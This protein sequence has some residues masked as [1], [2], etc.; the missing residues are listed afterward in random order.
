MRRRRRVRGIFV[1]GTDT[2]VGKTA[3]A[4]ALAA[5]G[6]VQGSD[7]G[8]MKPVASGGTLRDCGGRRHRVSD[9]AVRLTRASGVSD[10]WTLLNPVCFREPLAP[11]TAALRERR[12]AGIAAMLKAFAVLSAR[13][14]R[15]IVE[16]AGGWL[17]P[18]Q[19]RMTVADLA[20]RFGLPVLLVARPGLGTLNHTLLTLEAIRRR[21][22]RCLGVVINH[23]GPPPRNAMSRLAERTNPAILSRLAPVLG[24]LP[25]RP[26]L[27]APGGRRFQLRLA[28]WIADG[29]GA[30]T[31][32]ALLQQPFP[33]RV[34]SA[35]RLC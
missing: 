32:R 21:G 31:M 20:E 33:V 11:W 28:S 35:G 17:V 29:V 12:P 7:V 18:L 15:L 19:A 1:T 25:F 26:G 9:D 16:G 30:K 24:V 10:P 13:H 8:V 27:V 14:D 5:W 4:C 22:L 34:D 2:G 6:R 23:S 3:V